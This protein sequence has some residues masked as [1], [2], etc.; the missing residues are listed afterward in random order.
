MGLF[1][2]PTQHLTNTEDIF[3]MRYEKIDREVHLGRL[4]LVFKVSITFQRIIF[5]SVIYVN[6]KNNDRV[7]YF[8]Y[9]TQLSSSQFRPIDS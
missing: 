6:K 1:I 4:T 3:S 7:H 2:L 9:S 5:R 8:A